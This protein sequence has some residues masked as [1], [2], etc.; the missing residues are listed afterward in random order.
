ML[1]R[2]ARSNVRENLVMLSFIMG[3]F[4]PADSGS[5]WIRLFSATQLF[6]MTMGE[7]I[8]I[9]CSGATL[10]GFRADADR[11]GNR[12]YHRRRVAGCGLSVAPRWMVRLALGN[13]L[14]FLLAVRLVL[15]FALGIGNGSPLRLAD[16]GTGQ[17][18]HPAQT[19]GGS[20]TGQ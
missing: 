11:H 2:W 13:T 14:C 4:R 9:C 20:S 3:R 18:C 16:P 12:V 15:D 6:R 17:R 7:A 1:L 19:A 5:G 8:Q 10:S